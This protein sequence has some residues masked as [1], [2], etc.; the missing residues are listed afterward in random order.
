MTGWRLFEI[1]KVDR[2]PVSFSTLSI[3]P[4]T[5]WL[6]IIMLSKS[7]EDRAVPLPKCLHCFL[8]GAYQPP[9]S[10]GMIF[11]AGGWVVGAKHCEGWFVIFIMFYFWKVKGLDRSLW[12]FGLFL[13]LG[14][15]F[16]CFLSRFGEGDRRGPR[17]TG[18]KR[19]DIQES[20]I[21]YPSTN[22][23]PNWGVRGT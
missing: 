19:L 12:A 16:V 9:T 18:L 5:K 2:R 13:V 17:K 7:A 23:Q 4:L 20:A 21:Q 8:N 1:S 10:P 3:I 14:L 11:Q 15:G 6:I 22:K